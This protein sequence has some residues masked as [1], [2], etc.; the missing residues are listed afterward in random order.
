MGK[1]EVVEEYDHQIRSVSFVLKAPAVVR[2]LKFIN[3]GRK[4]PPLC[5]GNILAR[6]NF[7]CQYCAKALNSRDATLDH[8]VPRSQGGKTSWTNLVCCC[9]H[10]NRRKGGRTPAEAKM[11]LRAK[12][13]QPDW[14]PVLNVRL[15]GNLPEAWQIFLR[16]VG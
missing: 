7:E 13:V 16:V 8:V 6:D 12:P 2:L 14:L 3:I 10:C 9:T 4:T 11:P 1:I 15:N 5:R